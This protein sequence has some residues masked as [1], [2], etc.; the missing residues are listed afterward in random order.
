MSTQYSQGMRAQSGFNRLQVTVHL[1]ID[2]KSRDLQTELDQF[3]RFNVVSVVFRSCQ[4][5]VNNQLPLSAQPL[6]QFFRQLMLE[7]LAV[8]SVVLQN[9]VQI[10]S[11]VLTYII[12]NLH[13][14]KSLSRLA[15]SEL[16]L[17]TCSLFC[18]TNRYKLLFQNAR[19]LSALTLQMTDLKGLEFVSAWQ[20]QQLNLQTLNLSSCSLLH[21]NTLAL[22]HESKQLPQLQEVILDRTNI[23]LP[24]N[25]KKFRV[26]KRVSVVA[27]P[28]VASTDLQLYLQMIKGNSSALIDL[29]EYNY[30]LQSQELTKY[31]VSQ[32]AVAAVHL[33]N[34]AVA[35]K[36]IASYIEDMRSQDI[37]VRVVLDHRALTEQE[38]L[39]KDLAALEP[40]H[41]IEMNDWAFFNELNN[42]PLIVDTSI[43][44]MFNLRSFEQIKELDL[45]NQLNLDATIIRDLLGSRFTKNLKKLN[46]SSV[47]VD[48][49]H[50]IM[51]ANST[52]LASL[53]TIYVESVD[54]FTEQAYAYLGEQP[55]QIIFVPKDTSCMPLLNKYGDYRV[56]QNEADGYVVCQ[57]IQNGFFVLDKLRQVDDFETLALITINNIGNEPYTIA[58]KASFNSFKNKDS[59]FLIQDVS[60][61]HEDLAETVSIELDIEFYKLVNK[62]L[63][64]VVCSLNNISEV[65]QQFQTSE[66]PI[67]KNK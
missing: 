3:K 38:L 7:E 67:M 33:H 48:S 19:L 49:S 2:S 26:F 20:Q 60:I 65:V 8:Q 6:V 51:V 13:K 62:H 44:K 58:I 15:L 50:L 46:I 17:Q 31:C 47:A 5:A 27:C 25:L 18:Y 64:Q 42:Q 56:V 37:E 66:S 14:Q 4:Q 34:C 40:L 9:C 29:L 52:Q 41:K 57:R 24:A 43:K 11:D 36:Y 30:I 16:Q 32:R 28:R 59:S 54:V 35:D 61:A 23:V 55:T 1:T 63:F 21:A 39:K 10:P 12:V 45:S 22:L 53:E